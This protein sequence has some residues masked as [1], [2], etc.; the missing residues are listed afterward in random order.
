MPSERKRKE[1]HALTIFFD[2]DG[3]FHNILDLPEMK[4]VKKFLEATGMGLQ[5]PETHQRQVLERMAQVK[6]ARNGYRLSA[7]INLV[8]CIFFL[9]CMCMVS[10]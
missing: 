8:N 6:E 2:P 5:V 1:I 3:S 10:F 7:F 9:N 4:N